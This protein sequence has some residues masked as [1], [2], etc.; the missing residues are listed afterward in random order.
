MFVIEVV[1]TGRSE[2]QSVT[3][4]DSRRGLHDFKDYSPLLDS[5]ALL[6]SDIVAIGVLVSQFKS[7]TYYHSSWEAD[8]NLLVLALYTELPKLYRTSEV[9]AGGGAVP[10][11]S[12]LW[13]E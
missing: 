12:V 8:R 6:P 3:P 2:A 9:G 10:M 11:V 7:I 5:T 4:S 13:K 1:Q